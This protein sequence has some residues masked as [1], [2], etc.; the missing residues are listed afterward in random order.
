[1]FVPK[2]TTFL[3]IKRC[4][5][6]F[7]N[8]MCVWKDIKPTIVT[9]R[10]RKRTGV[11]TRSEPSHSPDSWSAPMKAP[12]VA[13]QH[14]DSAAGYCASKTLS[15]SENIMIHLHIF[16]SHTHACSGAHIKKTHL[17]CLRSQREERWRAVKCAK[18]LVGAQNNK[19]QYLHIINSPGRSIDQCSR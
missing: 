11:F 9:S 15:Y 14:A 3:F 18:M 4:A 1:M 7:Y 10:K 12:H 2:K 6:I 13:G 16:N 17:T 19:K 5:D 8:S